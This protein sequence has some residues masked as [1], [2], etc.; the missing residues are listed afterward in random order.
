[1]QA[2]ADRIYSA[3]AGS[4]AQHCPS[5]LED[6]EEIS[7]SH[8]IHS[9]LAELR[10]QVE[11]FRV[12][13]GKEFADV[14]RDLQRVAACADCL[15]LSACTD[16]QSKALDSSNA[17]VEHLLLPI[18][19]VFNVDYT[20][21]GACSG[22]PA[23]IYQRVKDET[24]T[25]D[26]ERPLQFLCAIMFSSL[27]NEKKASRAMP[28]GLL[29]SDLKLFIAR[30][31]VVNCKARAHTVETPQPSTPGTSSS[32]LDTAS[33]SE[34]A[35]SAPHRRIVSIQVE[36]MKRGYV[37]DE[38]FEEFR[39]EIDG[40]DGSESEIP[41]DFRAKKRKLQAEV[42]FRDNIS[43]SILK[44]IYHNVHA[45]FR[46]GRDAAKRQFLK[47]L[48]YL[49]RPEAEAVVSFEDTTDDASSDGMPFTTLS[50]LEMAYPR[51]LADVRNDD[52]NERLYE[53]LVSSHLYLQA[54]VTYS[55]LVKGKQ[56]RE[57]KKRMNK[58]VNILK[59]ALN[60][61][62]TLMHIPSQA[63]FWRVSVH[64]L[65]LVYTVALAF[66]RLLVQYEEVRVKRAQ[67]VGG[68]DL[69]RQTSDLYKTWAS[70][71]P[72]G[73]VADKSVRDGILVMTEEAFAVVCEQNLR[74]VHESL[75]DDVDDDGVFEDDPLEG[76]ELRML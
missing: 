30:M 55:V 76:A 72:G 71:V 14:R 42:E 44:H 1:V 19:A 15:V 4:A 58:E 57:E 75:R 48:G 9:S 46:K 73:P 24:L 38:M 17:G 45:F 50:N 7:D 36:W 27:P 56:G 6:E 26:N 68:L 43:R 63:S 34:T 20:A 10:S 62:V 37:R 32:Q 40:A 59:C 3:P 52:E 53:E 47:D 8:S 74:D 11:A 5:F 66:R 12:Y 29:H 2:M 21:A 69:G 41:Q 67:R 70:F 33:R 49:I 35:G 18:R 39:R 51:S 31:L 28:V 64:S 65:R 22:I 61:C 13:V 25:L 23:F 60:F 54:V 16:T